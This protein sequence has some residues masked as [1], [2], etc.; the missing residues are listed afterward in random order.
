MEPRYTLDDSP[1]LVTLEELLAANA[2]TPE[3]CEKIRALAL[4]RLAREALA[5]QDACNLSGVARTFAQVMRDL[6]ALGLGTHER[7]THPIAVLWADKISTL[8]RSYGTQH[9]PDAY[10]IVSKLAAQE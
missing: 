1:T 4:S 8:T 2:S 3:A 6:G 7:N 9:V 5:I 10:A